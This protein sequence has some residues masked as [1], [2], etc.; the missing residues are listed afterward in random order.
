MGRR[1]CLCAGRGQ[2]G[3]W[4]A[5]LT[6]PARTSGGRPHTAS[7]NSRC[8]RVVGLLLVRGVPTSGGVMAG[9]DSPA[10]ECAGGQGIVAA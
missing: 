10:A 1:V 9:R 6:T 5:P 7:E 2:L 8:R 3:L 4:P